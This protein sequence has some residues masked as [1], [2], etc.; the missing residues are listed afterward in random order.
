MSLDR[1]LA[2]APCSA[3]WANAVAVQPPTKASTRDTVVAAWAAACAVA[4]DA[5]NES[6]RS[7]NRAIPVPSAM[8]PKP[9]QIQLTSG[10]TKICSVTACDPASNAPRTMYRSS[11]NVRRMATSVVG[12]SSSCLWNDHLAG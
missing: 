5:A 3:C 7:G 9:N 10:L 11:A 1:P 8:M 2:P 6:A 4:R 12:G